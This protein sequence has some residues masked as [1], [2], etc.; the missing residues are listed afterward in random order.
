MI[1][2]RW[3]LLTPWVTL[4]AWWL[5]QLVM[6]TIAILLVVSGLALAVHGA[7]TLGGG[8]MALASLAIPVGAVLF[9]EGQWR[10][11][12]RERQGSE[13]VMEDWLTK[14]QRAKFPGD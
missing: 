3:T 9:V 4:V 1:P 6:I 2:R 11:D 10:M 13:G 14:R 5:G 7:L 12:I 8:A